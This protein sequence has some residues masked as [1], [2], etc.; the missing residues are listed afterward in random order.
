MFGGAPQTLPIPTAFM[1]QQPN[2][3]NPMIHQHLQ[4]LQQIIL[5]KDQ[6]LLLHRQRTAALETD[7]AK[8]SKVV[9]PNSSPASHD[10]NSAALR[11]Q[12]SKEQ[13]LN[14]VLNGKL[15][16]T[17]KALRDEQAKRKILEDKLFQMVAQKQAHAAAESAPNE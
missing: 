10:N 7:L 5:A 13:A 6:E 12:I 9:V 15:L 16:E 1:P 14:Q 17:E 3:D 2:A 11:D 8:A 4:Q